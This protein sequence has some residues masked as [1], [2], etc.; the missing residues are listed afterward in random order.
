MRPEIRLWLPVDVSVVR[1]VHL[2]GE[3]LEVC[4]RELEAQYGVPRCN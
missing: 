3:Q 2:S 1:Q 4:A